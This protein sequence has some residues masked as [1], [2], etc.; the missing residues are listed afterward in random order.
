MVLYDLFNGIKYAIKLD[1][2]YIDNN[3]FRMHYKLTVALLIGSSLLVTSSQLFGD[4]IS[5]IGANDDT[6]VPEQVLQTYCWI[7]STFTLP[8]ALGKQVGVE[9]A[10]PGVDTYTPNE[11]RQY[12]K[13]Y[14]WV[15]LVLF[16]QALGFLTPRYLW[17]QREAGQV[18]RL[19]G[20][21]NQPIVD[22][23]DQQIK[24]LVGYLANNYR[25]GQHRLYFLWY[26]VCETLNLA[27]VLLQMWLLNHFLGG[28]F[29]RYGWRVL[30]WSERDISERGPT[31]PMLA[32]FPRVTKCTFW[33]YGSSGDVQ[34]H[35]SLCILPLNIINE[36][37]YIFVWFWF[38]LLAS[39]SALVMIYRLLT[40]CFP[41]VRYL[42]LKS[43]A[44]LADSANVRL[45]VR[46]SDIGHW[47][48]WHLL[49]KNLDG[50]HCARVLDAYCDSVF[51]VGS[52]TGIVANNTNDKQVVIVNEII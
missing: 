26:V 9:V 31:D 20:Q 46:R 49:C 27:N 12:H 18:A 21:L 16:L 37:I 5:C 15:A 25:R 28:S 11:K 44:R 29:T 7:H 19:V 32:A 50:Q 40:I 52:G 43:R 6:Q 22:N 14:Q 24:L 34:R 30:E 38:A 51:G 39:I 42:A 41:S 1:T 10:H 35:D 3:V 48:L 17:K 13:Y 8:G 4:P 2:I 45:V 47:F 36:K 23:K 33:V